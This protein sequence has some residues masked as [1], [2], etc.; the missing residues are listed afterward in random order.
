[1]KP[2]MGF[3]RSVKLLDKKDV[4][5]TL[6]ALLALPISRFVGEIV[7]SHFPDFEDGTGDV[8]RVLLAWPRADKLRILSLASTDLDG[9]DWESS[10]SLGR[11]DALWPRVPNLVSLYLRGASNDAYGD[12]ADTVIGKLRL[13]E[14]RSFTRRATDLRKA[15]L[16]DILAADVPQLEELVL[17]LGE[18]AEVDARALAPVFSQKVFPKLKKLTLERTKN[19]LA[20]VEALAKSPLLPKL[21]RLS[22]AGGDLDDA[23]ARWLIKNAKAFAHLEYFGLSHNLFID[24]E[25]KVDAALPKGHTAGLRGSTSEH[26]YQDAIY[27]E[28]PSWDDVF[29]EDE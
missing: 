25:D 11:L 15:E 3:V 7:C 14:L 28:A 6:P 23:D 16:A 18:D 4:G 8:V 24:S 26:F 20:F 27:Q 2:F 12:D 21:K 22:V 17:I 13:P 9:D 29:G 5:K 19:T 1:V 10:P